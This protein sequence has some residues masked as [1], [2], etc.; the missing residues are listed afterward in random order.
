MMKTKLLFW[1]AFLSI[2]MQAQNI[3][4]PDANFKEALLGTNFNNYV[5]CYDH[6]NTN[7]LPDQN[8]DGEIQLSEAS[9][10]KK[11][12]FFQISNYITLEGI[13]SFT[14]LETIQYDNNGPSTHI[15]G[16]IGNI[17]IDA[18]SH[19]QAI[20]LSGCSVSKISIRNCPK[21][22]DID[23]M[24]KDSYNTPDYSV[25]GNTLEMVIDNCPKLEGI[26]WTNNNLGSANIKNVPNLKHLE[27]RGN[28]L[29]NF[30]ATQFTNLEYLDLSNNQH[31]DG[32][33]ISQEANGN[34][35]LTTLKING[36]MKLQYLDVSNQLL[37]SL[38][39][40]PMTNLTFL[41]CRNNKIS[42]LATPNNPDLKNFDC[43]KNLLTSLNLNNYNLIET[44]DCSYN[45]INSLNL[46]N[47]GIRYLSCDNNDLMMLDISN[48]RGLYYLNAMYNKLSS[49]IFNNQDSTLYNLNINYNNLNSLDL[50]GQKKLDFL[51]CSSNNLSVL[52]VS[53]NSDLD[54]IGF[55]NNPNLEFLLMKNGK[56][57]LI[58]DYASPTEIF[59]YNTFLNTNIKY[60]C[61]DESEAGIVKAILAHENKTANVNSYCSFTPGGN[62]NTISGTV[63]ID[64]NNNGCDA[65]DNPFEFL[66][67][68]ID[69]GTTSGETFGFKGWLNSRSP[70][71]DRYSL[72]PGTYY[73][74]VLV[75]SNN[76]TV[77]ESLDVNAIVSCSTGL[78]NANK[79][80]PQ[81]ITLQ[82]QDLT[83]QSMNVY[84]VPTHGELNIDSDSDIL[85]VEVHDAVGRILQKKHFAPAKSVELTISGEKGIY[86]LRIMT[87]QR[88]TNRKILKE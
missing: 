14:N 60:I 46:N 85:S 81:T 45:Q 74:K 5:I 15:H 84:P 86:F 9:L 28:Y 23:S 61:V 47:T 24:F 7:F 76:S 13:N 43:S 30:D 78:M 27:L 3:N 55:N 52:D 56:T 22:L 32:P 71:V 44:L 10:V 37:G 83:K 72:S 68:K 62:Y 4:F 18:L 25:Q 19:L 50:S 41:N 36:L 88:M 26:T 33:D 69:D 40:A 20:D 17:N 6:N 82:T 16:Y 2:G 66:K 65:S 8:K 39:V 34:P 63:K 79:I 53:A 48:V 67:L 57:Q 1:F 11:M 29:T 54:Y 73:I 77:R 38:N 31:L 87:K 80:V 49:I 70:K 51:D 58:G 12:V 42:N 75:Y 59:S 35:S 64:T 21:L